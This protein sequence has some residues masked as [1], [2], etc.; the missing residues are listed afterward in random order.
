MVVS[1][2]VVALFVRM[3]EAVPLSLVL[4]NASCTALSTVVD[5]EVL[6]VVDEGGDDDGG[7]GR[8]DGRGKGGGGE[9]SGGL[10]VGGGGVV[11][12]GE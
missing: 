6:A 12:S 4:S 3:A 2:A 11:G 7:D 8:G 10:G 9:G 1:V 5:V